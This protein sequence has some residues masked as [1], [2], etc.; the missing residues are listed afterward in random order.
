MSMTTTRRKFL[1]KTGAGIAVAG[2]ATAWP[3]PNRAIGAVDLVG[4]EWGGGFIDALKKI[5]AK[6]DKAQISWE[7]HQGG[8]AAILAKI[9]A[10]WPHPQ[11]DFVAVWDPVFNAMIR[12]DWAETITIE[13]VPNLKDIPKDL[14]FK[15]TNGN[16]KNVPRAIAGN[17]YGYRTD[18]SPVEV[19]GVEDLFSPQLKGQICWP[20]PLQSANMAMVTLALHEG[21]DEFNMEPAWKLMKELA[22]IG[23]IGRVAESDVD[24]ITSLT[25]GETSVSFVNM[26]A[27]V[28]I[29]RNVPVKHLTKQEG[30]KVGLFS[31]GFVVLKNSSNKKAALDFINFSIN[32]ENST[33]Y[34]ELAA[35]QLPDAICRGSS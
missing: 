20:H 11:Y 30:M 26:G 5:A 17:Y 34:T 35:E 23:N 29:A 27:W 25:T 21:G 2:F 9:K 6:Q 7:L 22:K 4:V 1:Q 31:S 14:I 15:D 18:R 10:T 16:W 28:N 12:E 32:P 13:D 24:F 33:I 3:G 8:S 19:K